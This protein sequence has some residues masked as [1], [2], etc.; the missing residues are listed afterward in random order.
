MYWRVYMQ[1]TEF[2]RVLNELIYFKNWKV[3]IAKDWGDMSKETAWYRG[4][5][6][7][8]LQIGKPYPSTQVNNRI[9]IFIMH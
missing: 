9:K 3:G 7:K 1:C 2:C 6:P 4:R 5:T 8:G